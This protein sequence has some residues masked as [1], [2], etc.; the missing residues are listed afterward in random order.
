MRQHEVNSEDLSVETIWG[1]L[2]LRF[3]VQVNVKL[4]TSL[5]KTV[6]C[7][8]ILKRYMYVI[9]S[10]PDGNDINYN[11]K[12]MELFSNYDTN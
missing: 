5:L 1:S 3:Y 4:K 11:H 10:H 7:D 12:S 8:Y 6:N 2:Y 9:S